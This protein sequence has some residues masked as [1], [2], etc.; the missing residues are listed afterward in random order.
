MANTAR[1][2]GIVLEYG[3]GATRVELDPAAAGLIIVGETRFEQFKSCAPGKPLILSLG[4]LLETGSTGVRSLTRTTT[5][6]V[7][8]ASDA[9]EE[10]WWF[11]GGDWIHPEEDPP[12]A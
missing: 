11:A 7:A 1:V 4:A 10:A 12:P 8:A 5:N 6:P 9:G 2:T 3:G